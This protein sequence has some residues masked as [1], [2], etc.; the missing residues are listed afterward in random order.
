M[1]SSDYYRRIISIKAD[2]TD[3]LNAGHAALLQSENK[4]AV[5]FYRL[6]AKDNKSDFE[7]AY[8]NDMAVLESLGADR[9][10]LLLILDTVLA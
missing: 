3:Y 8:S 5:N 4:E 2:S 7:L 1:K 10:T 9:N 6:A